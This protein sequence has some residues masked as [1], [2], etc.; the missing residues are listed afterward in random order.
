MNTYYKEQLAKI[1]PKSLGPAA[2]LQIKKCDNKTNW[3]SLNDESATELVAWLRGNF[4]II[5][6]DK[7]PDND[8]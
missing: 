7:Q 6:L 1:E 5:D 4:N 2:T 3:L 8:L